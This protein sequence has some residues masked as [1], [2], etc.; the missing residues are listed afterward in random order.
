MPDTS[1]TTSPATAGKSTKTGSQGTPDWTL[2]MLQAATSV[3]TEAKPDPVAKGIKDD[4]DKYLMSLLPKP[5]RPQ[6]DNLCVNPKPKVAPFCFQQT[7]ARQQADVTFD[8]S[9]DAA[10]AALRAALGQWR[11]ARSTYDFNVSQAQAALGQAVTAAVA[12]YEQVI[13]DDSRSREWYLY[14]TMKLSIAEAIQAYQGSAES[15]ADALAGA[16]GTLIA[17]HQSY[18][19]AIAAAQCQRLVDDATADQTFWQSVE[20]ALDAV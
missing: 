5:D 9:K 19:D 16:A 4:L 10:T 15:A 13:N 17:A 3:V 1:N 12:A 6:P 2:E 14:Y 7:L 11:L 18:A 20:S 8:A